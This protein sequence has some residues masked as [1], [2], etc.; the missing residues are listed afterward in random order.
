MKLQRSVSVGILALSVALLTACAGL[1]IAGPVNEGLPP[2]ELAG[3]LGVDFLPERPI[4][5]ATPEQI[6][7]GFVEAATSPAGNFEIARSFLASSVRDEWDPSAGVTID[8]PRSRSFSPVVGGTVT[9]TLTPAADVDDA[10]A[11]HVTE[12]PSVA[13]RSYAVAKQG[14]GEYRVVSAPDGIVLDAETFK[15]VYNPFTLMYFDTTYRFLVPDVRWFPART[16]IAT[17]ITSKLIDGA[18]SPWLAGAV[19][20]AFPQDVGLKSKTVPVT[21]GVAKV[22]LESSAL[23]LDELTLNRMQAQ[24]QASLASAGVGSVDMM[25]GP[26]VLAATATQ[27][28]STKVDGRALVQTADGFGFVSGDQL[29]PI[30]GLSQQIVKRG[31]RAIEVAGSQQFAAVLSD[32]GQVLRVPADGDPLSLDAR[33]GLIPPSVD[34]WGGIW[35]VPRDAPATMTASMPG[36]AALAIGGAWI[37]AAQISAMQLSRDGTRLAAIITVG[38]QT[39]VEVAGVVRDAQGVPSALG[40][41]LKIA[42]LAGEGTDIVWLDDTSIAVAMVDDDEPW[43]DT[44]LVGGPSARRDA[45]PGTLTLAGA[46][47]L[48]TLRLRTAEGMLFVQRASTWQVAGAGVLVLATQQGMP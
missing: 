1:P 3:S 36:A 35:S 33:P 18:P 34:P 11:Y 26:N 9:L 4:A 19:K 31:N 25:V 37:G 28:A 2:G 22:E 42:R 27:T 5:G 43:I 45:P 29:E 17:N 32:D 40:E 6:V 41:S 21:G 23:G 39:W 48:P 38:G 10:G 44:Q 13:T 20:S 7:E 15:V 8:Q 12:S 30:P 14:N 47:S 46:N 24:L 16:N